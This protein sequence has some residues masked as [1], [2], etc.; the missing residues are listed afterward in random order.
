MGQIINFVRNSKST[1]N[2]SEE[3]LIISISKLTNF[4]EDYLVFCPARE[5]VENQ[6]TLS[7]LIKQIFL[8]NKVGIKMA[9]ISPLEIETSPSEEVDQIEKKN[10]YSG[11]AYKIMKEISDLGGFAVKF[12]AADVNLAFGELST[13]S[14]LHLYN[15]ETKPLYAKTTRI[16][17]DFLTQINKSCILPVITPISFCKNNKKVI[18]NSCDFACSIAS[19]FKNSRVILSQNTEEFDLTQT[20]FSIR[21]LEDIALTKDDKKAH[22]LINILNSMKKGV[23]YIHMFD[24]ESSNIIKE[25]T[26]TSS[27]GILIYNDKEDI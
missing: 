3:D 17:S 1:S 4:L 2:K 15:K 26:F 14:S 24:F 10:L 27:S 12:S 8:L 5:D 13:V 22:K 11:Y 23:D 16:N 21:K 25:I 18:L 7:Y 6:S 19:N 9:I 20:I